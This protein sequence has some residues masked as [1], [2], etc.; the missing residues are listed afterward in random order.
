M[1]KNMTAVSIFLMNLNTIYFSAWREIF[2]STPINNVEVMY[3]L[4]SYYEARKFLWF[5]GWVTI[6]A[7]PG[8]G[9][10]TL[11]E[12]IA[13]SFVRKPFKY[14]RDANANERAH[15]RDNSFDEE[16]RG[17]YEC[18][19][20]NSPEEW[21]Q[22]VKPDTDQVV[23]LDDIFGPASFS[24]TRVEKWKP[25]LEDIY[26]RATEQRPHCLVIITIHKHQL[27]KL[28]PDVR[29]IP[30]FKP[31]EPFDLTDT[32]HN[33]ESYEK[34]RL[35]T[36]NCEYY[37]HKISYK[38]ED[39]V[40]SGNLYQAFPLACRWYAQIRSFHMEGQ[41]FF[42]NPERSFTN[43]IDKVFSFDKTVMFTLAS[44]VLFDG[45]IELDKYSFEDYTDRQQNV[46]RQ[47]RQLLEV[48]VEIG[49]PQ[50]RF[51]AEL[52][53]GVFFQPKYLH[54]W[55][56]THERILHLVAEALAKKYPNKMVELCSIN[57]LMERYRTSNYFGGTLDSVIHVYNKEFEEL[58]QRFTFEILSGNMRT[59]A[60][61]PS[62]SDAKFA[63]SWFM[64]M[65]DMGSLLPVAYQKGPY[66][67][68]IFYWLCFYGHEPS[69]KHF[70]THE[71]LEEVREEQWFKD[72]KDL[73]LLAACCGFSI[74][75][76][77][78]GKLVKLLLENG[79]TPTYNETL[80]EEDCTDLF[81]FVTSYLIKIKAP[82]IHI[83]ANQCNF[84]TINNLAE[85]GV[86]VNEPSA[87]G[88]YPLHR[89]GNNI[90]DGA[91]RALVKL[92]AD[93]SKTTP[94]GKIPLHMAMLA[95]Y[96]H[97]IRQINWAGS[98]VR[99]GVMDNGWSYL[100]TA[101]CLDD[102]KVGKLITNN[103]MDYSGNTSKDPMSPLHCAAALGNTDIC[104][105]L[106]EKDDKE[107]VNKKCSGG[108]TA[109]HLAVLFYHND[110]IRMLISKKADVN[111]VDDNKMSPL[112]LACEHG[113]IEICNY[114][115][116]NGAKPELLTQEGE[117]PITLAAKNKHVELV[118]LLIKEG[119]EL[120]MPKMRDE[121]PRDR[122]EIKRML[123]M[124]QH[125]KYRG[126]FNKFM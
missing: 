113:Y 124:M 24:I 5:H 65:A 120:E 106:L 71:D 32:Q 61:H 62:L 17:I 36:P 68:S 111:V 27:E 118:K 14:P 95:G 121:N 52:L 103:L 101:V 83:A 73:S 59:I 69:V 57:F 102:E 94:T 82:L 44:A 18:V 107:F 96:E 21:H 19:R 40:R 55:E 79:V 80:S 110:I 30:F 105:T 116:E 15:Y 117:L 58:S 109:L 35:L 22:K 23:L 112:H 31:Y 76:N 9:K 46:F 10:S 72:E 41:I 114:L 74:N 2:A 11:A 54:C 60:S 66:N 90:E 115:L 47:L 91:A 4:K 81:G 122:Q 8:D 50:I 28:P 48:P 86:D 126:R 89:A 56:F 100:Y 51:A 123:M 108:Y 53:N 29:R 98:N 99:E 93:A 87:D 26:T 20:V 16:G 78:T 97:Q 85:S 12:K 42:K 25:I 119:I 84:E 33:P 38:D 77:G 6:T 88:W 45:S 64:F 49:L 39:D 7:H 43:V 1:F 37:N 13:I 75:G 3:T 70:L 63:E 34:L 104:K 125:P 92:K 67:R